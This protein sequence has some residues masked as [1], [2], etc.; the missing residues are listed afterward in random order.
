MVAGDGTTN[1]LYSQVEVASGEASARAT[2]IFGMAC[3]MADV[4]KLKRWPKRYA[5]AHRSAMKRKIDTRQTTDP[6]R[7]AL[8]PEMRDVLALMP[9]ED[10]R[11][12]L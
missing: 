7:T 9:G 1:I 2:T 11:R 12:Q 8:A 6:G 4:Q 5:S 3:S 10:Q